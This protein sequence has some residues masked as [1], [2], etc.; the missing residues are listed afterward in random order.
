MECS[1]N[2]KTESSA[3]SYLAKQ[4]DEAYDFMMEAVRRPVAECGEALVSLEKAVAD[5]GVDVE[6]SRKP[7]A[8]GLP[9]LFFLREGQINGF[10]QA[11]AEMNRRGWAMRIEDGYR[12]RKM[13]KFI[14]LDPSV[15]DVILRV[16]IRELGG[17]TP[18]PEHM[19][20]RALTLVAQIPKTGTHMSGSALDISVID[21][22]TGLDV[23]RGA[24]YLEMSELTPMDSPFIST[25]ARK[26]RQEITAIMRD[27]GFVEYPYEFWHY[28]SGDV[29]EDILYD[30]PGPARYGAVDRV[31]DSG[32]IQAIPNPELP[33]ND[34]DEIKNEIEAALRR[35]SSAE[36]SPAPAQSALKRR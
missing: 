33:L 29:Y 7:H 32:I 24:P 21:R 16:V 15:F 6:F 14:G 30:R 36:S 13:Q 11:T 2:S 35:I 31:P 3:I 28:S 17:R 20:K 26:N 22:N 10:L 19:F 34:M 5:A 9:R 1:E 23:D 8:L 25:A 4:L 18:S 12:S 27:A